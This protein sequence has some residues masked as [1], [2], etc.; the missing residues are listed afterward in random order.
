[1]NDEY[2]NSKTDREMLRR[3]HE[4]DERLG[5][6]PEPHYVE[7]CDGQCPDHRAILTSEAQEAISRQFHVAYQAR[8]AGYPGWRGLFPQAAP[9]VSEDD[10]VQQARIHSGMTNLEIVN[11]ILR[12]VDADRLEG[13]VDDLNERAFAVSGPEPA[14]LTYWGRVGERWGRLVHMFLYHD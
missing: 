11:E 9:Y 6:Y 14:P 7:D 5:G 4:Q 1:M 8:E 2:D 13:F 3:H 10:M 12:V